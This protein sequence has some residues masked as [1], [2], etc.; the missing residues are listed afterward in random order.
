MEFEHIS[1]FFL[2][3][4]LA[5]H[6]ALALIF[7]GVVYINPLYIETTTNIIRIGI[8]IILILRFNP[9][10]KSNIK[11]YDRELIFNASVLLLF[12]ELIEKYILKNF[13]IDKTIKKTVSEAKTEV[14]KMAD[15]AENT[16][17]KR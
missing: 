7:L 15:E 2:L 17:N 8:A 13:D 16:M 6:I 10:V 9:F 14:K 4:L 11:N 3:S 5:S 1:R 12:N